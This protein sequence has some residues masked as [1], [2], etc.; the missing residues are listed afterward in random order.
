[1]L[2]QRHNVLLGSGRGE[3]H[4]VRQIAVS[5]VVSARDGKGLGERAP[6][7]RMAGCALLLSVHRHTQIHVSAPIM[8]QEEIAMREI[9]LRMRAFSHEDIL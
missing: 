2:V 9:Q 1:M 7:C 3:G 4:L 8:Q 5:C 6:C